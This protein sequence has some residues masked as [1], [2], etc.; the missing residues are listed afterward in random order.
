MA[1]KRK[2][3][4]ADEFHEQSQKQMQEQRQEKRRKQLHKLQ[5]LMPDEE[6]GHTHTQEK[7]YELQKVLTQL[8]INF[9][10]IIEIGEQTILSQKMW[11]KLRKI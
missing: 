5:E 9:C 6:K 2:R 10:R 8:E 7:L 11:K 3:E 4:E 1:T